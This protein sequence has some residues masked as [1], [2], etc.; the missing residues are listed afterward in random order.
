M[1]LNFYGFDPSYHI[2]RYRFVHRTPHAWTPLYLAGHRRLDWARA[3][4]C[5]PRR[6]CPGI[7]AAASRLSPAPAMRANGG[8]AAASRASAFARSSTA[9]RT[10]ARRLGTQQR[11]RRRDS[12]PGTGAITAGIRRALVTPGAAGLAPTPDRRE[13]AMA[14]PSASTSAF[15]PAPRVAARRSTCHPTCSP[16]PTASPSCAIPPARR[17][18]YPFINCTQCG[19]RYTLIR[20]N[21]L[22]PAQH[23]HGGVHAVCRLRGRVRQSARP[24]LSRAAA[25]L[26]GLRPDARMGGADAADRRTTGRRSTPRCACCATAASLPRAASAAT[27]CCATPAREEAVARLRARKR[28]PAKPLA[29]MLPC[30]GDDGLDAVRGRGDDRRRGSRTPR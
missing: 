26:P 28:R 27:T 30:R 12:R 5:M 9:W 7:H 25:R 24:A 13:A 4:R 10:A 14:R 8:S 1:R 2:A 18:D 20:R 11:R 19:P 21:A 3:S 15:W 29:V 23:D 6:T 16:A 22:R 17:Y